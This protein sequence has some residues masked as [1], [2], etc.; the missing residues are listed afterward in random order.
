MTSI[1]NFLLRD[2]IFFN[3][4]LDLFNIFTNKVDRYL[5]VQKMIEH[6]ENINISP[7][8]ILQ[9]DESSITTLLSSLDK[10]FIKSIFKEYKPTIVIHLEYYR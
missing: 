4:L 2:L 9:F 7:E 5:L 6:G 10:E 3:G 8:N 1:I